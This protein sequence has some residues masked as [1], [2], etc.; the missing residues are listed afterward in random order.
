MENYFLCVAC[1]E[2]NVAVEAMN[3]CLV[4]G[5]EVSMLIKEQLMHLLTLTKATRH[6]L[7]TLYRLSS[8]W[9]EASPSFV[10]LISHFEW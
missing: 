4:V 2:R 5:T 7:P 8:R 1:S 6:T 3:R 10:G 9:K